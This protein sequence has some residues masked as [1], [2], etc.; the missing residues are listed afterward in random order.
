[1]NPR[2]IYLILLYTR[3][4]TDFHTTISGEVN[5]GDPG[6]HG[7]GPHLPN[8]LSENVLLKKC[9]AWSVVIKMKWSASDGCFW[10]P[11]TK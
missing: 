8:Q 9:S 3:E 7:I 1:M 2:Q 10:E 6:G 4:L 5:S 11:T